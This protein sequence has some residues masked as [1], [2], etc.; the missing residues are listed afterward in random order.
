MLYPISMLY[1]IFSLSGYSVKW[2]S[3]FSGEPISKSVTMPFLRKH[4]YQFLFPIEYVWFA[5]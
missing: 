4:V 3:D 2:T 5:L 1:S